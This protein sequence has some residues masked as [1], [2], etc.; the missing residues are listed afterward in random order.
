MKV[1]ASPSVAA[2]GNALPA[3]CDISVTNICNAA[4]DFCGFSRDKK[5]VGPRRYLDREAFARALPI[6]RRRHIKYVTFQG[7]EPLLHPDIAELVA[8]ASRAGM[9]CSLISNGWFLTRHIEGLARA[10]LKRLLVSIDSHSMLE[11][12]INRGLNGL[13]RRISE[14]IAAAREHGIPTCATVTVS[15]LVRYDALP[16]TLARLGFDSVAFSYPRR[17]PF[18]STSLVYDEASALIDLD[19]DELL[20]ALHAIARMKRHFRVVDPAGALAEVERFVRGEEQL[21][22]CIG[23]RKYFYIDW[24]LDIWRCEAWSAP[25]GSVFDLDRLPDETEPCNACMMSCYRHGSVLMHGAIAAAD[26]YE[27]V[28]HGRVRAAVSALCQRGVMYSL[29]S[30]STESLPR[31]VFRHK[32]RTTARAP[33]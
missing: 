10:G 12:E 14:G 18:G 25:M 5:R 9:V 19:Q 4:C 1:S 11:H 30:L 21:V 31:E 8:S 22:P 20:D 3:I 28:K 2:S 33:K 7:G 15:R 13:E 32:P 29:W 26:A 24:N 27:A 23:G 17:A 16:E 6:L